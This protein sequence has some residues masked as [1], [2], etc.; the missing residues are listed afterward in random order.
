MKGIP[1]KVVLSPHL[2]SMWT[3]VNTGV[4]ENRMPP[5]MLYHQFP[6]SLTSLYIGVNPHCKEQTHI[7]LI[8]FPA[9]PWKIVQFNRQNSL[10]FPSP[11]QGTS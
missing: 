6:P 1:S 8:M 2:I 11:G 5:D 4:S 7:I 3:C 10:Y 9:Y